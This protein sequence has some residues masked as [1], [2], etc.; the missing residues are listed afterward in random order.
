MSNSNVVYPLQNSFIY[1]DIYD[2]TAPYTTF[3]FSLSNNSNYSI[4]VKDTGYINA[5]FLC[6][7]FGKKLNQFT[8]LNIYK[9]QLERLS[10]KHKCECVIWYFA[11]G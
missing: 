4:C 3:D 6:E 10:K 7:H 2:I 5:S 8:V 11:K 9:N 1:A